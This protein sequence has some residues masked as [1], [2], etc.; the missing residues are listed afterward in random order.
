VTNLPLTLAI[1]DYEHARDLVTGAV[2]PQGIDLMAFNHP[3][4]EIYYRFVRHL[5]WDVAELSFGNFVSFIA[6]GDSRMVGM[7]VF[8]SRMFRH[9]AI[10][11][12]EGGPIQRAGDLA[13]RRIGIPQWSQTATIYVRGWMMHQLGIPLDEIQWVQAGM[14]RAGR[15]DLAPMNLPREISLERVVDATLPDLLSSGRIDA[16]ISARAPAPGYSGIR[17]LFPDPTDEEKRYF[18]ETGIFPIMHC[19]VIKREAYERNRW[20]ARNLF[21]AFD[22]AKNR[23]LQRIAE[24]GQSH[25]PIPWV[26]SHMASTQQLLFPDGNCW[27]YGVEPNLNTISQF[28]SYCHEQGICRRLLSPEDIFVP[29]LLDKIAF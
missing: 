3:I 25:T 27:P 26:H 8:P 20:I 12:L 2:R 18:R 13:G 6:S 7:P 28:L 1:G 17:R 19:V 14:T 24:V 21:E 10:Y 15:E 5:E 11:I 16:F 22:E 29:E 4:E 9:G 23:G